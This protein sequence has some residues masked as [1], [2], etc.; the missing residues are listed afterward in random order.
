MPETKTMMACLSRVVQ[1]E[2]QH[3]GK[4]NAE[5]KM[6]KNAKGSREVCSLKWIGIRQRRQAMIMQ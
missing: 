6:Q 2:M 3:S 4:C 5:C 1:G